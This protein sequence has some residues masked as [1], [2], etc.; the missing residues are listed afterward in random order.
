MSAESE[1]KLRFPALGTICTFFGS[2]IFVSPFWNDTKTLVTCC[3]LHPLLRYSCAYFEKGSIAAHL[4][5]GSYFLN[6]F[7]LGFELLWHSILIVGMK[8]VYCHCCPVRLPF[9]N[10]EVVVTHVT[11]KTD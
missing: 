9:E 1:S 6:L 2:R 10:M 4:A 7:V 11:Y 3:L 5:S 8:Q